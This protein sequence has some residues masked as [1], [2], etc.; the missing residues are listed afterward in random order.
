MDE[1]SQ[2][3]CGRIQIIDDL[4]AYEPDEQFSV[5]LVSATPTG[6]FGSNETCITI[7]DNDGESLDHTDLGNILL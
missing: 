4:L 7:M 2:M 3:M 1:A 5:S 6:V